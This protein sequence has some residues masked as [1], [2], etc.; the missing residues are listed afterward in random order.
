MGENNVSEWMSKRTRPTGRRRGRWKLLAQ[1][2]SIIYQPLIKDIPQWSNYTAGLCY[3][4]AIKDVHKMHWRGF[5][6]DGSLIN[7]LENTLT[8]RPEVNVLC[9][10]IDT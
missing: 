7:V 3:K 1:Y 6:L 5:L 2:T 9:T 4:P 10:K 8:K